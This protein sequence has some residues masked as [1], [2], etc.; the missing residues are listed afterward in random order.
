MTTPESPT[1]TSSLS[2]PPA[3][4]WH[5]EV[6]APLRE[7]LRPWPGV[8]PRQVGDPIVPLIHDI[9]LYLLPRLIERDADGIALIKDTMR[10]Y[11]GSGQ[12]LGAVARDGAM[13]HDIRGRP[14][15][16]VA[17]WERAAASRGLETLRQIALKHAP[18]KTTD[19]IMVQ[20]KALKVTAVL[21][22][23]QLQ[24]S[25]ASTIMLTVATGDGA[26][27]TAKIT[28]KAYRRALNQI[29]A[30]GADQ[31][32]VILQGSIRRPGE[33]EGGGIS[34]QPRKAPP[35]PSEGETAAA[36]DETAQG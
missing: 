28:G 14:V 22:A 2:G 25:D 33:I 1:T 13:R 16:P 6:L 36:P 27:A 30:S 29:A 21:P 5:I 17:E 19:E 4:S 3:A 26:K 11:Y 34:V 23:E 7:R 32:V 20:I 8:L 10:R 15:A 24:P 35:S 31:V 18:P 9:E 12:Y